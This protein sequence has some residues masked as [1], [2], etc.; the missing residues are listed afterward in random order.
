MVFGVGATGWPVNTLH[1][2]V[3]FSFFSFVLSIFHLLVFKECAKGK[4]LFP[5]AL[6]KK[7]NLNK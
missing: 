7:K 2:N 1:P 6:K 4:K 3:F 5:L